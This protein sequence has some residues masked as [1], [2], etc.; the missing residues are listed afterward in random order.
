MALLSFGL[1]TPGAIIKLRHAAE[2][3]SPSYFKP[4]AR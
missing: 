4:Q 3:A 2:A 1:D